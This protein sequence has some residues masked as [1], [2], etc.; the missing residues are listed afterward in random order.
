M[1]AEVVLKPKAPFRV[2]IYAPCIRPDA[3]AGLSEAEIG[4]LEVLRGNRKVKLAE[5]FHIEGDGAAKA[6]ELTIRLVGDLSK[7]RQVGFEMRSG[8]IV[9][10]GPIGLL[11]GEHMR[12]GTIEVRGSVGQFPGIH[13][14][15]GAILIHGDCGGRPG[16]FMRGGKIII[17]GHL[18]VVPPGFNILRLSKSVKFGGEKIPGPFYTFIGDLTEDGDGR[19]HVAKK[20]NPHL[21]SYERYL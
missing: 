5:L 16:A 1:A 7:V 10:E 20:P 3:F 8:R 14:Q 19:L 17:C 15:D 13:M 6:E 4:S 18:P 9:V 21:A 2:P 12:G 11:T